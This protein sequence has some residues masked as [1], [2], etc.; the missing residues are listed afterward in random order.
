MVDMTLSDR[1]GSKWGKKKCRYAFPMASAGTRAYVTPAKPTETDD[2]TAS[3]T[4]FVK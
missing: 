1:Q 3:S 4:T 2:I